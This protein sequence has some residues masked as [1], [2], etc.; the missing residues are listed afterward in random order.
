ME[1]NNKFLGKIV[2]VVID[3]ALG[4]PH[5]KFPQMLYE[6]NY[7]YVPNTISGDNMELDVYVLGVDKPLKTFEGRVIAIIRRNEQDDDK[8]I[9]VP[10]GMNFTDDEIEKA[11]GF[12]EKYF[13]HKLVR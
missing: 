13:S 4:S 7:G 10:D 6:V 2:S 11:V 8:L 3:R 1:N 12:Q 5:P 9:V